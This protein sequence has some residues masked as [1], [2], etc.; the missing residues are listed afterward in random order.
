MVLFSSPQSI[1]EGQISA[2][3][4]IETLLA[5]G[6]S[7]AIYFYS[8]SALHIVIGATLA[9][10]LLL[11]TDAS[12]RQG[13]ELA[14]RL[15]GVAGK[16][17]RK[18]SGWSDRL[19]RTKPGKI[20]AN[21][22][23][24]PIMLFI[25]VAVVIA[26]TFLAKFAVVIYNIFTNF[27]HSFG[28]VPHNWRRI[29]LCTD[30]KTVPELVPGI[31]SYASY[32][33]ELKDLDDFRI[34]DLIKETFSSGGEIPDYVFMPLVVVFLYVPASLYRW[35]LKSTA[36]IWSPL[37][38]VFRPIKGVDNVEHYASGIISVG[39]YKVSRAF[40]LLTIALFVGKIYLWV[41]W[42]KI[43]PALT[44][45][46][47]WQVLNSLILPEDVALWQIAALFN[48]VLTWVIYFYASQYV[49]DTQDKT[50]EHRGAKL[51]FKSTFITRNILSIYTS[52][53]LLYITFELA[54]DL[55]FPTLRFIVFP[56]MK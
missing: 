38:W 33:V 14:D 21:W 12:T 35:S 43:S 1:A 49:H 27:M 40:S 19:E 7:L 52:L 3:A 46:P 13:L 17:F 34:S 15:I 41:S 24:R 2:A 6:V 22:I 31:E 23:V 54:H 51:F 16:V 29:V 48:A 9:P 36:I 44:A 45:I 8:G 32:R 55:E 53:C 56:W 18:I 10:F 47:N 39:F 4:V 5:I 30:S 11:R 25:I 37:L 42:T 20:L 28:S 26:A 50:V